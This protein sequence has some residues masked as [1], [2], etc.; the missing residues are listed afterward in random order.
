MTASHLFKI[1]T[2][3][4]AFDNRKYR[5]LLDD[6]GYIFDALT[7]FLNNLSKKDGRGMREGLDKEMRALFD[8]LKK[9][10]LTD[11]QRNEVKNVAKQTLETLKAEKIKVERWRESTQLRAQVKTTI[12]YTLQWLLQ[13]VYSEIEDDKKMNVVYQHIFTNYYGG[14]KS[15]YNVKIA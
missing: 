8:L 3:T 13:E 7:D 14:E 1:Q 6:I 5:K 15:V 11:K 2:M 10:T 9:N 12:Y 4:E